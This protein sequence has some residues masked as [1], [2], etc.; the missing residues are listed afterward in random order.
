[1]KTNETNSRPTTDGIEG[2]QLRLALVELA[3]IEREIAE[4][5]QRPAA[6]RDEEPLLSLRA[7]RTALLRT[8]L[9]RLRRDPP[10]LS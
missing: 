7:C 10:K 3:R 9:L 5:E 1:M 4:L 2:S 8:A 6:L